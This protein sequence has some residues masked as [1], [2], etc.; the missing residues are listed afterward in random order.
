MPNNRN[1]VNLIGKLIL[2]QNYRYIGIVIR[3]ANRRVFNIIFRK[4][5][6]DLIANLDKK[7]DT[8]REA[9]AK[10]QQSFQQAQLK[11]AMKA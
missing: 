5:T 4:R 8:H 2:S 6:E 11:A 3:L 10:L 1:S 9:L 7:Q